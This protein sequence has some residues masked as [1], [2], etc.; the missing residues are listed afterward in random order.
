MRSP[1]T[2]ITPFSSEYNDGVL[3]VILPIQTSEFG[4]AIIL[5]A[6]PD[7]LDIPSFYQRGDGNFWV[8]LSSRDVVGTIALLDIGDRHGAIRKMFVKAPFRGRE[9]GVSWRLLKTLLEWS[10]SRHMSAIYLGTTEQ[11]LA[12]HRFYEKN[13]FRPVP[14][15]DLP[16]AFPVMSIDTRFYKLD[17]LPPNREGYQPS[18][19]DQAARA[20]RRLFLAVLSGLS[21]YD[22]GAMGLK[23]HRL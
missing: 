20:Y 5:E 9:T 3:E 10:V 16:P 17:L 23:A 12:A 8:A 4:I 11:F 19:P 21:I 1:A 7:L 2:T 13:G 22:N 14:R 18:W 6:Q 15:P